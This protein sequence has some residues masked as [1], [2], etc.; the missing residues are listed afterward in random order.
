M[1]F[2]A[3][4]PD[5]KEMTWPTVNV[6][7]LGGFVGAALTTVPAGNEAEDTL[8]VPGAGPPGATIKV[9]PMEDAVPEL[10]VGF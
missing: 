1:T 7:A 9:P 3:P 10:P 6:A 2:E 4:W 8:I 5:T